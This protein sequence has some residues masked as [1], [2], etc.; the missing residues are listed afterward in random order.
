MKSLGY[1]STWATTCF[2]NGGC[3]AKVFAHTNG[4]GD[5]VLFDELG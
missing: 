4:R 3:G 2:I 5:F 1:S